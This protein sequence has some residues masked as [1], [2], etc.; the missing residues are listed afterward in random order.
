MGEFL[1]F[2]VLDL[3]LPGELSF[4]YSFYFNKNYYAIV[5]NTVKNFFANFIDKSKIKFTFI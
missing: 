2:F 3:Q 4:L 1:Y 5:S